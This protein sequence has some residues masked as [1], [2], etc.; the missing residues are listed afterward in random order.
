MHGALRFFT[1]L[2]IASLIFSCKQ[3]RVP[4]RVEQPCPPPDKFALKLKRLLQVDEVLVAGMKSKKSLC[5]YVVLIGAKASPLSF[6]YSDGV[7]ILGVGYEESGGDFKPFVSEFTGSG[8]K[9]EER[10]GKK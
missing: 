4:V 1:F 7:I 2:L 10:G 8:E 6:Y 5:A 9:E 3:E